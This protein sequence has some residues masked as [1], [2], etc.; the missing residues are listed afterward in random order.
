MK[1]YVTESSPSATV[2]KIVTVG[3]RGSTQDNVAC[4]MKSRALRQSR[5]VWHYETN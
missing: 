3:Q 1:F 4:C 2:Y 5:K